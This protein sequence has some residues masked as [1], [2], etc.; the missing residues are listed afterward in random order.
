MTIEQAIYFKVLLSNGYTEE[1]LQYVNTSLDTQSTLSDVVLELSYAGNDREKLISILSEYLIE[2][3]NDE[4]DFDG[5]LI[6]MFLAFFRRKYRE[7]N[8]PLDELVTVMH[9]CAMCYSNLYN[10]FGNSLWYTMYILDECYEFGERTHFL[11]MLNDFLDYK[12]PM[13]FSDFCS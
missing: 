2:V 11:Q 13:R 9:S 3:K 8:M 1:V 10:V 12:K 6:D 4:I 7:E 5:K